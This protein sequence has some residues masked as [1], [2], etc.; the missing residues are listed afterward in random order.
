LIGI[1]PSLHSL[2]GLLAA[3]LIG[4]QTANFAR[5]FR[6]TVSRILSLETVPKGITM[7]EGKFVDVAVF[8]MGIDVSSLNIKRKD[9]EVAEW[10]QLLKQRYVG[11]K[12]IVGRDKLDEVQGVRHKLL[13]FETFLSR[14]PQFHGE[15]CPFHILHIVSL[16]VHFAAGCSHSG[17]PFNNGGE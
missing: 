14:F 9:P 17:C 1:D 15:V 4:F 7:S 2:H 8:P 6:Q 3:D 10:V 16:D 5:H 12:I 11:M 13:A